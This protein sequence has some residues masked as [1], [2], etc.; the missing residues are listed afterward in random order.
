MLFRS[1]T[2]WGALTRVRRRAVFGVVATLLSLV[3]VIAVPL[4]GVLPGAPPAAIWLGLAG[5]G[6]LALVAAAS[7]E[8]GVRLVRRGVD[9]LDHSTE[10]WE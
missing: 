10:G 9:R 7:V 5:A 4:A 2:G 8:R 6:V 1:L 3:L